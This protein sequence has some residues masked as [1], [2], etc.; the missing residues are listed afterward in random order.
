MT[1]D[2][3]VIDEEKID[4]VKLIFPSVASDD[5]GNIWVGTSQ[6]VS[7]IDG[8]S[9][10]SYASPDLH[11]S[12]VSSTAFDSNGDKWFASPLGGITHFDGINFTVYDTSNGLLSQ[13][14][15]DLVIRFTLVKYIIQFYNASH[16]FFSYLVNHISINTFYGISQTR[17]CLM[18]AT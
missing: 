10:T 8:S 1:I 2:F 5:R 9:W 13:N 12:G 18:Y 17:I 7:V 11:W 6:G 15:T 16:F 3:K 4:G 14:V